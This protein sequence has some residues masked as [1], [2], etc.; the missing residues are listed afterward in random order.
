M[1]WLLE[2]AQTECETKGKRM[3]DKTAQEHIEDYLSDRISASK[4]LTLVTP[5]DFIGSVAN[6]IDDLRA[7]LARSEERWQ[8]AILANADLAEKFGKMMEERDWWRNQATIAMNYLNH[9]KFIETD[10]TGQPYP[11]ELRDRLP[12][13]PPTPHRRGCDS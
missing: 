2:A 5:M 1:P 10:G 9:C 12:L 6:T 4:L 8:K 3:R 13:H 11:N 7:E